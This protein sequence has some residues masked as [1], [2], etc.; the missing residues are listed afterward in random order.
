MNLP[1]A[2]GNG[3]T[4]K[5]AARTR[6]WE[7]KELLGPYVPKREETMGVPLFYKEETHSLAACSFTL[8]LDP[9]PRLE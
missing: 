6:N 9:K 3:M 7:Q 8:S 4:L 5:E 1:L 2:F